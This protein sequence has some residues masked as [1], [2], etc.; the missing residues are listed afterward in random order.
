MKKRI[1][2][3]RLNYTKS[4]KQFILEG[5]QEILGSGFLTKQARSD[6]S[7]RMFRWALRNTNTYEITKKDTIKNL[8]F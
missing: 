4:E 8:Y 2:L 3:L 7:A 1:P 5:V 6:E